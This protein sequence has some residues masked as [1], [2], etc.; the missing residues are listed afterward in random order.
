MEKCLS[1]ISIALLN[2][3]AASFLILESTIWCVGSLIGKHAF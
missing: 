3:Q 2:N 1:L